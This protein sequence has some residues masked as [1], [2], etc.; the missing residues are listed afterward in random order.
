M[1]KKCE[2]N[3]Y[4]KLSAPTL[5]HRSEGAPL[6]QLN[7]SSCAGQVCA[8]AFTYAL[9]NEPLPTLAALDS[10]KVEIKFF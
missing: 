9:D 5:T 10:L 6:S 3:K 2:K 4:K 1:R 8:P 7:N